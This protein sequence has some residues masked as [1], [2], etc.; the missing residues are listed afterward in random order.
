MVSSLES[1]DT[2]PSTKR[3]S[4]VILRNISQGLPYGNANYADDNTH[5]P[6]V[7]SVKRE[8]KKSP[9]R[10]FLHRDLSAEVI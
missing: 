2:D 7:G 8:D 9:G 6:D 1:H 3:L 10:S 4:E 5:Y